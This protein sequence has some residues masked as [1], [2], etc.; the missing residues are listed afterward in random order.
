MSYLQTFSISAGE[1]RT[2]TIDFTS[3][4]PSG[5]LLASGTVAALNIF[6]NLIDN[7][8][9]GSTTATIS[10]DDLQ[11]SVVI[12]GVL[13]GER[14]KVTFTLTCDDATPSILKESIL[15]IGID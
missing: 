7:T 6:T 5:V 15:V 10:A 9:L 1:T 12:T 4:L 13:S 8:I 14:Y 3:R 11:S 2:L